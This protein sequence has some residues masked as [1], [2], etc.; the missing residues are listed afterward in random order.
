MA[1]NFQLISLT[2]GQPVPFTEIDEQICQNILKIPAHPKNYGGSYT[3][4][5]AFNW[6]DTIGFQIACG[7]PLHSDKLLEYYQT[8][9]I[10]QEDLNVII[11]IIYLLRKPYESKSWYSFGKQIQHS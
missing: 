8:S 2:T 11:E 7:K 10:W 4:R 6:F 9:D 1:Q 5:K 3:D